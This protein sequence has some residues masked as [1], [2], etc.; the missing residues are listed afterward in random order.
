MM[1]QDELAAIADSC[2]VTLCRALIWDK[3][4]RR[5]CAV[6]RG[7]VIQANYNQTMHVDFGV[8][9]HQARL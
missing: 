4:G 2:D 3:E 7:P 9:A 6:C 1:K 8:N 5:V